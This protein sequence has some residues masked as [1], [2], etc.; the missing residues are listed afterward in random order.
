[1]SS[2]KIISNRQYSDTCFELTLERNGLEYTP[3]SCASIMGRSYSF[4]SSPNNYYIKFIIK[5]FENGAVSSKITNL[6]DKDAIEIDEVFSFFYPGHAEKYCYICTGTGVAPFMS[7]LMTYSTK[8]KCIL[9]GGKTVNDLYFKDYL[10][11]HF[12]N[13]HYAVSQEQTHYPK[14]V[15]DLLDKLPISDN[16]VYYVC[17]LEGMITDVSKY[18]FDKGITYNNIQ[19]ELFYMKI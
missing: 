16:M 4:C 19:Q 11:N 17:G 6:T 9:Y 14:R 12:D 3:G 8:P 18:L 5:R 2:H 13:V 15:T 10:T 1:M 7:A